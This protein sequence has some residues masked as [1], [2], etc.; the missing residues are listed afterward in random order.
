MKRRISFPLAA[1]L[2]TLLA[3]GIFAGCS[4]QLLSL[5]GRQVEDNLRA[6][7]VGELPDGLHVLV[8]GAGG[9]LP[10]ANRS[11]ACLLVIAGE[12]VMLFDSGG[13][14][15]RNMALSGFAP[16]LVE[17]VFLTHF[18]S[19][20]IDGLG[21]IATLRWAA[22]GWPEPLTVHG[23]QGVGDIVHGFNLA[24]RQDQTYRTAHHGPQVTPPAS[25]G[26]SASAFAPPAEGNAPVVFERGDL[27]VRAF[28]VDH[29]PVSPAVG[30]RIDYK[31][32]S[33][34]ISGDTAKSD[35]LIAL[36]EGVDV[37]FHEALSKVLVGVMNE[38]AKRAGD[39]TMEKITLDILDYH[40]SPVEAAESAEAAGAEALVVYHVVPPLPLAP[41][42]SLFGEGMDEVYEGSIEIAVDG[43]FVS[44]PAGTNEIEIESP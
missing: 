15:S 17:R 37:L 23:P 40:A 35:N 30:Y 6:D 18:H 20:H 42:E 26:L 22:G 5:M 1:I 4:N 19:D 43:T 14:A 8:C 28:A 29:E 34:A 2:L 36:A 13:G 3:L 11:P 16:P 24:Y 31:D 25:A 44:L 32:R 7:P 41:L 33:I 39:A 38:A 9:P 10:A 21:E 12:T 27:R